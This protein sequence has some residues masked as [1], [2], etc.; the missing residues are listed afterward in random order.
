MC[1]NVELQ[2]NRDGA[3]SGFNSK[4]VARVRSPPMSGC[5]KGQ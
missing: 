1:A 4:Y 2:A 3:E 5:E